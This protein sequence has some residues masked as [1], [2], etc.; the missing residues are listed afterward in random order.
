MTTDDDRKKSHDNSGHT[1]HDRLE[2]ASKEDK[3]DRS[4]SLTREDRQVTR[5]ELP[6]TL[7]AEDTGAT[8][9]DE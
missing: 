1:R 4:T 5:D 7:P 9:R 3:S 6:P 2:K 8:G